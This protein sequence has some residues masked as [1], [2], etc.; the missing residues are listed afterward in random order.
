MGY[1]KVPILN[2]TKTIYKDKVQKEIKY[3]IYC[4]PNEGD[5]YVWVLGNHTTL[6]E[7][8]Y[9]LK[10]PEKYWDEISENLYCP[11]CGKQGFE[12]YEDIGLE[13]KY[14][15]RIQKHINEA[16]CKFGKE[17]RKFENDIELFPTLALENPL[18][19]KILKEIK[20]GAIPLT[21]LSGKWIRARRVE[22]ESIL[23]SDQMY[24]PPKGKPG[25]GRYNHAGQSV[26]YLADNEDSAAQECLGMINQSGIVWLQEFEIKLINNI[27]NLK[28]NW[29]DLGPD[30]GALIVALLSSNILER[31]VENRN[32]KWKPQYFAT[33]FIAD[34]ARLRGLNGIMYNSTRSYGTNIVLFK[35]ADDFITPKGEPY[36]YTYDEKKYN[37]IYDF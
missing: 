21:N 9:E 15:I 18:G 8:F 28:S 24:A 26:L 16:E 30:N 32:D 23:K 7:L 35:E 19:R 17:I 4:Q 10:V 2:K 12:P 14:D 1:K 11:Y 34:C 37:S 6:D 36:L 5:S 25:E 3:C 27:L 33:R 13:D 22:D 20:N 29:D 31:K